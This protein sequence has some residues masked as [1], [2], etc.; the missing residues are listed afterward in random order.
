[1][2]LDCFLSTELRRLGGLHARQ[3]GVEVERCSVASGVDRRIALRRRTIHRRARTFYRHHHLRAAVLDRLKGGNGL[4]E[5][6]A[7]LGVGHAHGQALLGDTQLLGRQCHGRDAAR[8]PHG[9]LQARTP[10]DKGVAIEPH[11]ACLH[12]GQATRAVD[13]GPLLDLQSLH[14]RRHGKQQCFAVGAARRQQQQVSLRRRAGPRPF[15]CQRPS[16]VV[17]R[18]VGGAAVVVAAVFVGQRG[19]ALS[20]RQCGQP[21]P[22]CL[23]I[24]RL[25]QQ[26]SS[27]HHAV[28]EGHA[29]QPAT[30][31]FLQQRQLDDAQPQAT[32]R[33]GQM[34][35][36]PAHGGHL[37][38]Q[39]AVD[40]IGGIGRGPRRRR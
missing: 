38:P 29:G 4:T 19:D 8:T 18:G 16:A 34:H 36:A 30:Q 26:S 9:R 39:G 27:Q 14:R 22:L 25:A 33:F 32:L 31:L 7:F 37:P 1:M 10:R 40:A 24:G 12:G 15:A 17:G 21:S 6:H 28:E 13:G 35:A 23:C 3:C 20:G 5:L 2:Q 11:A